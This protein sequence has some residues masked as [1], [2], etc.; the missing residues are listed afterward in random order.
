MRLIVHIMR[1]DAYNS[2]IDAADDACVPN[3]V[4]CCVLGGIIRAAC[5]I[6]PIMDHRC[7]YR[8]IRCYRML[9]CA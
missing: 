8:I 4:P 6:T 2:V 1:Y 7:L 5:A 3:S 9:Y